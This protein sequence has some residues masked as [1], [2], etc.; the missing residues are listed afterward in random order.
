MVLHSRTGH[1]IRFDVL[2]Y[3]LPHIIDDK[4]DSNWLVIRINVATPEAQWERTDPGMLTWEVKEMSDWFR[5]LSE[6]TS[7]ENALYFTLENNLFIELQNDCTAENKR[8]RML[9]DGWFHPH[10]QP[11]NVPIPIEF[12]ADN[13]ELKRISEDLL[14]E[15]ERFPER[16]VEGAITDTPY[17]ILGCNECMSN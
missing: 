4:W 2:G 15:L 9:F 16:S 1:E 5:A 7:P 11:D 3:E 6:N 10:P 17:L 14:K 12:E 13:A 8:I